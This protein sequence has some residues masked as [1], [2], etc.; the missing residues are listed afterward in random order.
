MTERF[1]KIGKTGIE[2]DIRLNPNNALG[3]NSFE[4][5]FEKIKYNLDG[6][7][8]LKCN[9]EKIWAL[10]SLE[11]FSGYSEFGDLGFFKRILE[12]VGLTQE[13]FEKEAKGKRTFNFYWNLKKSEVLR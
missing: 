9:K 11:M 1:V 12:Y 5:G 7:K 4:Q 3:V 2:R 6:I 10:A 13:E 8:N